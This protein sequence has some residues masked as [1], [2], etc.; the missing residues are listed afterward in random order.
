MGCRFIYEAFIYLLVKASFRHGCLKCLGQISHTNNVCR[1][2]GNPVCDDP[3]AKSHCNKFNGTD[4]NVTLPTPNI[5][6][7]PSCTS[8]TCDT[9]NNQ[10]LVY[11]LYVL[12]TCRCAYPLRVGYRLKSPGFAIFPPYE[13]GFQHYLSSGLNLSDYQVNV[14]SY[15]WQT[16]PRLAMDIKLFPTN[17]TSQFTQSEVEHLYST[18]VTWNMPDNNTFGPY[19]VVSFVIGNPY[20]SKSAHLLSV[21]K[22]KTCF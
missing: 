20:N 19:E 11:G 3:S 21:C 4:A 9:A 10:E 14:S 13:Q 17:S 12:G 6:S 2:Y 15:S 7:L 8:E 16:G 18:F 22:P 1:L 5:S